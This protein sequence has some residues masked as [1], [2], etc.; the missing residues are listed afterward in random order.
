PLSL[1]DALPISRAISTSTSYCRGVRPSTARSR[2]ATCSGN[3]AASATGVG[4]LQAGGGPVGGATNWLGNSIP[5]ASTSLIAACNIS[6][7][8]SLG[9][10]PTTP[11]GRPPDH[12]AG[13]VRDV[14]SKTAL[15][16]YASRAIRTIW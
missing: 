15:G 12:G 4:G 7:E 5:P 8:A 14:N 16:R 11:V 10:Q 2:R 6:A 1:T 3:T 9:R 13:S